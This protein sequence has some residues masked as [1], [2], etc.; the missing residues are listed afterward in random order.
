MCSFNLKLINVKYNCLLIGIFLGTLF[1]NCK[2][3]FPLNADYKDIPVVYGILNYQDSIHYLKIYKGFQPK[4]GSVYIDAQNPDSIY[5]YDDVLVILEEYDENEIRTQRPDILLGITSD[6][7]RDPGIFYWNEDKIIYFTTEPIFMNNIYYIKIINKKN[8]NIIQGKT[9]IVNDFKIAIMAS[10]INMLSKTSHVV[11]NPALNAA[12]N[13]Y[14]IH[15]IFYYFEVDI[16]TQAV[17]TFKITKNITPQIGSQF[18]YDKYHNEISKEYVP[19]FYDD[20]AVHIKPNNN[21]IRY[22]GTPGSNGSCIE[23]QAWA[24][25]EDLYNFLISNKPSSSFMEMN[26]RYS[27]LTAS[28]GLTFGFLS[29]RSKC[30]SRFFSITK[31]SEDSVISGQKTNM[32]S[33]RPWIEYKP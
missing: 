11:L 31:E 13:G 17:T 10:N 5:Y 18:K 12:E 19:T 32:L 33:F 2:P 30:P 6:F 24:V 23:I 27:N 8:G 25:G 22:I 1:Y 21:V 29:S 7:E 15:V 16:L 3:D 20:I 4:N 28:E 14:E 26:I 9:K